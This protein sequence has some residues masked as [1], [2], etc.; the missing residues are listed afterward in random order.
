[1][2]TRF[3]IILFGAAGL[4]G[5]YGV[6][7]LRKL[8]TQ[9]NLTWAV[10]GRSET[11]INSILSQLEEETGDKTI[12]KIPIILADMSD[13]KTIQAMTSKTRVLVNACGPLRTIGGIVVECCIETKTHYI[14]ISGEENFMHKLRLE[15]HEEAKKAGIYVVSACGFHSVLYDLGVLQLQEKFPGSLNSADIF[16]KADRDVPSPGGPSY[17]VSSWKSIIDVTL[18][19]RELKELAARLPPINTPKLKPQ[20][21]PRYIPFRHQFEEGWA[22][23]L[24]SC[25]IG[26]IQRTQQYMYQE[27]K[28]RPVQ[29]Q[30]YYMLKHLWYLFFV[31]T[32]GIIFTLLV[33]FEFGRKLLLKYPFIFSCGLFD[34][35]EPLKEMI[36]TTWF[37]ITLL[38]K[39]WKNK[40]VKPGEEY[41]SEPDHGMIIQYKG[42]DLAY[43]TTGLCAALSGIIMASETSKIPKTYGVIT[44]G[45][46]FG[47]TTFMQ[48][49]LENGISAE[50]K[51]FPL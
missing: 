24:K 13:K 9:K 17:N 44:P 27:K 6:K 31:V 22:T 33:Y 11:K 14:D 16:I 47:E 29:I 20:N 39:G 21:S 48:Q 50:V 34:N 38:G 3:D 15:Y 25:D 43:G 46:A 4:A 42:I 37:R 36:E 28:L 41:S 49:L 23:M 18:N 2:E 35:K 40:T 30:T 7:Y 8:A 12:S 10:A 1:M 51:E 26:V 45:V 19:K 5:R 32:F